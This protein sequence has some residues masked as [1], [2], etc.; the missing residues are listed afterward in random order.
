LSPDGAYKLNL[1]VTPG[2][3]VSS[4]IVEG[5]KAFGQARPGGAYLITDTGRL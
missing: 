3:S 4:D 5:L 1:L 2:P